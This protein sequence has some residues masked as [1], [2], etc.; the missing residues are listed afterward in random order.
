[1]RLGV[2]REVVERGRRS[3]RRKTAD[4][5]KLSPAFRTAVR[6]R[7]LPVVVMT[8]PSPRTLSPD[9]AR[10]WIARQTAPRSTR[11]QMLLEESPCRGA[12]VQFVASDDP[13]AL[14]AV[15]IHNGKWAAL[16]IPEANLEPPTLKALLDHVA[17]AIVA[18]LNLKLV[19]AV[20]DDQ[21]NVNAEVFRACSYA[22]ISEIARYRLLIDSRNVNSDPMQ[23]S[24]PPR[25]LAEAADVFR[26]TQAGSLDLPE[27]APDVP[28]ELPA[29]Q[30][31]RIY[32]HEAETACGLSITDP[33]GREVCHVAYFGVVPEFRGRGLGRQILNSVAAEAA[34]SA[35]KSL[36][37][38]VD[39]RNR[40]AVRIYEAAGFQR[41]GIRSLWALRSG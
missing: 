40:Y 18:P 17:A 6:T 27:I 4:C 23:P 1:M 26:R 7:L 24:R 29:A 15:Q 36:T 37:A 33:I 39:V 12:N 9:E 16:T 31:C 11:W 22:R 20:L 21:D 13:I 34:K 35:A 3:H 8:G 25:D 19:C 38:D 41:E 14:I 28:F 10:E 5:L 30:T 32:S 2:A